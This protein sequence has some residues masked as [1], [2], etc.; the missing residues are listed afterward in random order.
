MNG[1]SWLLH[2]PAYLKLISI[3]PHIDEEKLAIDM[4]GV[5]TADL[6]EKT[7]LA[8]IQIWNVVNQAAKAGKIQKLKWGLYGPVVTKQE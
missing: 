8:E 4:I 1:R 5:S 2:Y 3:S 7:G 6:K